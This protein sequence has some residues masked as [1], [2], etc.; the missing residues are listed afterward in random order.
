MLGAVMAE[1]LVRPLFA[2]PVDV[3]GDVHGE[4]E[5]LEQLLWRLGYSSEGLHPEGRRLVFVGDLTDRGPDSPAVVALVRRLV[6]AGRAQCVLGNH[7][8]NILA[9]CPKTETSWLR[10]D[11]EPFR[12]QG[13]VVPQAK[14]EGRERED[15]LAFFR[16]LPLALERPDVRVVHACWD[17]GMVGRVRGETDV[18]GLYEQYRAAIEDGLRREGVGDELEGTLAHQNRN[19]VKLLTSGPEE[20]SP[21]AWELNGKVRF[22]RRVAWWEQY[23]DGAL[24]LFG[25]YWRTTLPGEAPVERLFEDTP[26]NEALGPGPAMCIDYSAGK[27]YKERLAPG[28]AGAFRTRL[29]ALRLPERVL[30]F[31]NE[32]GAVP[33]A[34][35]AQCPMTNDQCPMPNDQ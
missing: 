10:D 15:I 18:V 3:V 23:R 8:F 5:A 9:W 32:P 24:C 17:A 30:L 14:V 19:P 31:D 26:P 11:V 16:A 29:A 6:E 22:E 21:V 2:N 4:V 27:R 34:F 20:R 12:H 1:G 7:E 25:H 28:F 33:L 35:N 13:V